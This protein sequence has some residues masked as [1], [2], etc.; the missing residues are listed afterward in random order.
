[1]VRTQ[2]Y[3]HVAHR[4]ARA[5]PAAPRPRHLSPSASTH[6]HLSLRQ[7]PSP[8]RRPPARHV[9]LD[10]L[11]R[12]ARQ[13]R[14]FLYQKSLEQKEQQ[15][16]QRKQAVKDLLAKGKEVPRGHGAGEREMRMDAAQDGA[17]PLSRSTTARRLHSLTSVPTSNRAPHPHRR[18]VRPGRHRR[19]ARPHH[20]LAR[21][22][23]QAAAVRQGA[24][25]LASHLLPPLR[26]PAH[27]A[28]HARRSCASAC[29]TR[30][31]STAVT[32]S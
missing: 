18:R 28:V 7:P 14:E 20:H 8:P 24:S 19:P 17:S 21:P 30:P 32:M 25:S 29:P 6:P 3:S 9:P 16:W 23:V 27:P 11:R 26:S 31:A 13:R 10:Q 4:A 5:D 15:I 12:Q 2:F 22:L 1:M